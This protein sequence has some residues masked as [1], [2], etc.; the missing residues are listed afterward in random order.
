MTQP[1]KLASAKLPADFL[2]WLKIEAAKKGV[3]MYELILK[4]FNWKGKP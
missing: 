3:P 1:T 2:R 4:K